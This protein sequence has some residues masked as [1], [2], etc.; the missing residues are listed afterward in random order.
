MDQSVVCDNFIGGA[1]VKG[2]AGSQSI[3]SPH[4]GRELGKTS[5]PSLEQIQKAIEA[6]A[7]AQKEWGKQPPK[8]RAK[9]L[10]EFRNILL[11]EAEN[12]ARLKSAESGKTF[13][14]G[15]AGLAKGIEVLEFAL[16]I[17]NLDLPRT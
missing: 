10:F 1:W 17:Q 9:V 5:T 4:D 2:E 3:L 16:A 11:R 12:I 8:E 13:E 14:E 7:R 6:A 15:K